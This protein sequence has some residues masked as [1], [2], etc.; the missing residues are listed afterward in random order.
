LIAGFGLTEPLYGRHLTPF[1]P[2]LRTFCAVFS[3]VI[4]VATTAWGI[5][6]ALAPMLQIRTIVRSRSSAGVSIG[7]FRVL[8]IGFV[9]WLI[10]GLDRHDP[11]LII[12]NTTALA[13]A[14]A[15]IAVA[16]RF[17]PRD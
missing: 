11:V 4:A 14:I 13:A 1:V 6:M 16:L 3:T 10:Y 15:A 5:V 7:Y 12:A 8:T 17:R 2:T 9:L